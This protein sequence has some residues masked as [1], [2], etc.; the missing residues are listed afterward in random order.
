M[1]VSQL[2]LRKEELFH[3][4]AAGRYLSFWG[5]ASPSHAGVRVIGQP[6]EHGLGIKAIGCLLVAGTRLL[7]LLLLLMLPLP[8][9]LL[10]LLPD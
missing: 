10:L 2:L 8:L 7:V 5:Y 1:H 4:R 9:P 6:P 3:S